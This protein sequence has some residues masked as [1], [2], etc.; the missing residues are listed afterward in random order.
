MQFHAND[1]VSVVKAEFESKLTQ[2][3]SFKPRKYGLFINR[4]GTHEFMDPKLELNTFDLPT[5]VSFII[6]DKYLQL[7]NGE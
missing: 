2:N 3:E 4:D 7:T 1:T 5:P 6:Y